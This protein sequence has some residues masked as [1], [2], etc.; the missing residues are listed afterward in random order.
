[1]CRKSDASVNVSVPDGAR[2]ILLGPDAW[3]RLEI[4]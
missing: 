3:I 1:M 2:Q 4:S